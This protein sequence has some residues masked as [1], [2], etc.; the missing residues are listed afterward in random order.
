ME[1]LEL[2]MAGM[3]GRLDQI[4]SGACWEW[5]GAID[6][7]GYGKYSIGGRRVMAHRYAWSLV[8]GPIPAGM[9]IWH[10]CGNFRC[11]RPDHLE[12]LT[13]G[14]QR[15]RTKLAITPE[16]FWALVE[17]LP[18]PPLS[19][20]A[21]ASKARERIERI[22]SGTSAEVVVGGCWIWQGRVTPRGYGTFV[23]RGQ[24]VVAH[25]YTYTLAHGPIPPDLQLLHRC[26]VPRCVR[27]DHLALADRK[28]ISRHIWQATTHCLH[29]HPRT[30]ENLHTTPKGKQLCRLCHNDRI[31]R[32]ATKRRKEQREQLREAQRPEERQEE[33]QDTDE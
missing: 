19:D 15:M 32:Y 33:R 7:C 20:D 28:A 30:P 18:D 22:A 3:S 1:L 29:G 25:H 17:K 11:V 12:L 14:E 16:R 10:A 21:G 8:N 5:Q 13:R 27:P 31:R 4:D 2:D 6:L 23:L 9:V 24:H 26:G